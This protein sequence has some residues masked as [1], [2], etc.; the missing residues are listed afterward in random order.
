LHRFPGPA[1]AR[2]RTATLMTNVTWGGRRITGYCR[3]D[4]NCGP[5]PPNEIAGTIALRELTEE[6]ITAD[7][8]IHHMHIT[9][10]QFDTWSRIRDSTVATDCDWPRFPLG[11]LWSEPTS[12]Q[13]R[14]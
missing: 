5:S 14:L 9:A 12:M 6:V 2:D 7:I 3:P 11:L 1:I 10:R 13:S 4:L 8:R